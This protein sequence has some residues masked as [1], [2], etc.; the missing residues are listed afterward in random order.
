MESTIVKVITV[1]L[2]IIGLVALV[3]VLGMMGMHHSMMGETGMFAA[4]SAMC[5]NMMASQ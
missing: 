1:L 5:G 2:A 4:M 3:G